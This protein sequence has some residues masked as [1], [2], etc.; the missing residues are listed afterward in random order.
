MA[1]SQGICCMCQGALTHVLMVASMP[2]VCVR[3]GCQLIQQ[4]ESLLQRTDSI[5]S[6]SSG[7][8]TLHSSYAAHPPG[9]VMSAT[10]SCRPSSLCALQLPCVPH[11]LPCCLPACEKPG[12]RPLT[13]PSAARTASPPF[14]TS[15]EG[16]TLSTQS[17]RSTRPHSAGPEQLQL[18]VA[19]VA[20]AA[21]AAAAAGGAPPALALQTAMAQVSMC[22]C[23]VHAP[24]G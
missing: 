7:H 3:D 16:L 11:P 20:S 4:V 14:T 17:Q 19:A 21:S 22:A 24:S 18:Q 1:C 23:V 9:W 8:S 6:R 5:L 2:C 13:P 15:W 12:W 10:G